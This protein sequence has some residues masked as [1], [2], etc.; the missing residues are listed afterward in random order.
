MESRILQ[1]LLEKYSW[2]KAMFISNQNI[3]EFFERNRS[4]INYEDFVL[5]RDYFHKTLN[6]YRSAFKE[7]GAWFANEDGNEPDAANMAG[8]KEKPMT[9]PRNYVKFEET[10]KLK[11]Y[12]RKTIKIYLSAVRMIHAWSM[13]N[14]NKHIDDMNHS[15][16]R[17]FFLYLNNDRMSSASTVRVYRFALAYYFNNMLNMTIDLSFVEGVRNSKHIPVVFTRDEIAML[18]N[19]IQNLKHRT[20]IALIYSSGLRLAELLNLKVRDVNLERLSIHVKEGKG[21]KDRITI[22]SDKIAD[23]LRSFMEGKRGDEF[24][25]LAS[26]TD[27]HGRSHPLSGRTVQKVL[28]KALEKAGINKKASPH[29]LR[30]SFATHLLENGISLRHIQALLGHKNI[31]TT[32]I[33][34]KVYDPQLKGIRSPL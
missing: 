8:S 28:E 24:I 17:D 25:F 31:A 10:L 2:K 13:T 19:S 11:R 12:S 15:D 4:R 33:Y 16:F 1:M 32:S 20:M 7:I 27:R 26:G 30:H 14:K 22:F 29:D 23:D 5:V 3:M 6:V 18:L 21:K 9:L 34:T